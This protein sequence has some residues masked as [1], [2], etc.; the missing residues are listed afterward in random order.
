VFSRDKVG[1]GRFPGPWDAEMVEQLP[2]P[3]PQ[4]AA[5]E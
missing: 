5:A 2:M 1:R 4:P 3:Q